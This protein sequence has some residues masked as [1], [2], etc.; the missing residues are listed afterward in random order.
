[1]ASTFIRR[2]NEINN[3]VVICRCAK[4]GELVG[5]SPSYVL[6]KVMEDLHQCSQGRQP[7]KR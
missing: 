2:P 1:M 3:D 5:G 7:D 6:M 4:C